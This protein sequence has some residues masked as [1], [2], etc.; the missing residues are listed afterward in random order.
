VDARF[1]AAADVGSGVSVGTGVSD[2]IGVSSGKGVT[3][4]DTSGV[5][6][7]SPESVVDSETD[8]VS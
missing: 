1:E 4:D 7:S 3:V 2:G 6:A 8:P 5:S